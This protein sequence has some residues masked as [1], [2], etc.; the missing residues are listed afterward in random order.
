MAFNFFIKH[1]KNGLELGK[2]SLRK[3]C[4]LVEGEDDAIF[5]DHLLTQLKHDP[6]LVCVLETK[7]RDNLPKFLRLISL[8]PAFTSGSIASIVVLFDAD[9]APGE[10][11]QRVNDAYKKIELE[12]PKSGEFCNKTIPGTGLYLFP[13]D[14]RRGNLEDLFIGMLRGNN[15]IR[16]NAAEAVT[17]QI[18]E[19]GVDLNKLSKRTMQTVLAV[20]TPK[21]AAGI[22]RGL[23]N[24]ALELDIKQFKELHEFID[25]ISKA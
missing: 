23:R 21:L 7:G 17:K 16:C 3:H 9:D 24:G 18:I 11:E 15:D 22:G 5:L 25:S 13:G 4:Y 14:G 1:D 8:D 19:S 20:S 10:T 12:M 6:A 2:N